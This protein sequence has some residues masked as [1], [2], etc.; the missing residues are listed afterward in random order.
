M[1]LKW[2]INSIVIMLLCMVAILGLAHRDAAVAAEVGSD[3]IEGTLLDQ[4]TTD[5]SA[6]F[7]IR[8]TEQADL[9]PAYSMDW[10]ARGDFVYNT[11]RKTADR[12][13]ANAK[14]ILD[15]QGLSYQTFIAGNDLYVGG[16]T[17]ISTNGLT[18]LNELAALP[19]VSTI[20]ATRTYSIDP[21]IEV[22]PLD[23]ISWAGDLLANQALSTVGSSTNATMDWGIT[24]TKAN[25]FWTKFG[26]QGD[27]IVVASID[28]GVQWNHPALDQA[29]KCGTNPADPACWYDPTGQCNGTGACDNNGHG[30]HTMGTMVADD[31]PSLTYIAGMAPN[32]KWIACKGCATNNCSD[33]DLNACADW[34]LAPNNNPANRPDVVNNSW[35][36]GGGETWFQ[37][38]VQAWRAAGIFP[39]FSAGNGGPGCSTLGSPGDYQDSFASAAHDSSRNIAS[40]SSRGPSA[41]GDTP[42]TKPNLSAPGVNICSTIPNSS[43]SCGYSGTSMASP[44]T[45]GAVAL[46]WSCNP[47]L[48]GQIDATFQLLQN[49]ADTAPAGNCG[50]PP[51]GQGNYTYGYGYLDVLSAG[52]VSCSG[53]KGTLNGHVYG[54]HA[55]SIEGAIVTIVP[56]ITGN[57]TQV[58][59]DATGFYTLDLAVGTY[60]VTASKTG[61]ASQTANN[62]VITENAT[63]GLDFSLIFQGTWVQITLPP[64]CPDWT[65]YDGEY[66]EG[67]VYFL[68]GRGGPAGDQTLGDVISYNPMTNTCLDT[69]INM[70][71]PVSN[72]TISLVNDGIADLLCIFGGRQSDG[73]QTL[74]VQCYNPH[75]NSAS[76]VSN[77][78]VAWAGYTPG[79]EV[80]VDNKV[81]IF[82]GFN[83]AG[84]TYVTARTEVYD[85][86]AESFTP[87]G[88]LNVARSYIMAASVDGL[89]YAFGGDTWNGAN[90]VAST[91]AEVFDP[92]GGTWND[93]AVADL[94]AASG[95]GRAYGFDSSSSYRLA[96]KIVLA[97]GGQWPADTNEALTYDVTTN[98]Y[99]TSFPNL[100][101]SRRDQAGFFVPDKQ[102]TMWVFGGRSVADIPPFAPPEYFRINPWEIY[103]PII[104]K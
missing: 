71:T 79:A 32:A 65:R 13:Q 2:V 8:F 22:K 25:Q 62:V 88:N 104:Y 96:G 70:P 84:P 58:Y 14:A 54:E 16:G 15:M 76:V 42:Y 7:I 35:G 3:K 99:D 24:D 27:G 23:N 39:A 46:L 74:N 48:K 61:Y 47:S 83:Q 85:P 1:K 28:T 102:G 41:Y 26:V 29:F 86:V 64:G 33:I 75:A 98:S 53:P 92:A 63:T 97:G 10:D 34:I 68:G 31:D 9:S 20:R 49:N 59:T 67:L 40:F 50:T 37:A 21:I 51:D 90:L 100:N 17:Q 11:L 91:K 5:G 4:I 60:N 38:K 72:Y 18:I 78:P 94:P 56:T 101:I 103:Q 44:H 69:G 95:E 19:E 81:Y 80:V 77:L 45:A 93:T 55:N 87:L 12:S 89:I 66:Y 52:V 6:D 82:G 57:Q 43:W 30:T 36:G 73:S